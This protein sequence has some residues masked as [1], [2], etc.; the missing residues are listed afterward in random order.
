MRIFSI[1]MGASILFGA[2][3]L[4]FAHAEAQNRIIDKI[5]QNEM[6]DILRGLGHE[7][8]IA[9][10]EKEK[11]LKTTLSDYKVDIYFNGCGTD[12]CNGL[13]FSLGFDKAPNYTVEFANKWNNEHI[14]ARA[15]VDPSDGSFYLDYDVLVTGVRQEFV[16]ANVAL[17][18]ELIEDLDDA[19]K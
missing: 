17:Y 18:E 14:Y 16:K 10:G 2:A 13:Q 15:N 6:A 7:V 19:A 1:L 8:E 11:Y 4:N 12:G 3:Q 5:T 9:Q